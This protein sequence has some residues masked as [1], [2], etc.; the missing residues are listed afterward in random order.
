MYRCNSGYIPCD[1]QEEAR[2][3]QHEEVL[4]GI[5][6]QGDEF[7]AAMKELW[8]V[9][10]EFLS[11]GEYEAC[12]EEKDFEHCSSFAADAFI[13]GKFKT[14]E[15]LYD[16]LKLLRRSC[17][18]CFPP[19]TEVLMGDGSRKNIEDV[20]PGDQVLATDP[21]ARRTAVRGVTQQIVTEDDKHF[22]E[23]TVANRAGP[24]KLTAT[25]EHPFWSPSEQRWIGAGELAPGMTLLSSD[26]STVRVEGNRPFSQRQKTYN[27][28]VADIHT[29]YV[30][31]GDTPVLVHNS[32]PGCGTNWMSSDKIPHHY[33]KKS[34]QGVM[35]AED[36]GV[37]GPYNKA[38]AQ[39]FVQAVERFVKNPGTRQLQGTY[40]GQD[41][42]HYV[43]DT[44][45]HASFAANGPNVGEY[46]GGWRSTGDQ[47][48]HLLQN[49]KL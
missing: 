46:L 35:H 20:Q 22:N 29:Y 49:G 34:D 25:H 3:C 1:P 24:E 44:G 33:M 39:E 43:D 32:G 6:A 27:L 13:G 18:K 47:L 14:L 17:L 9:T 38:N 11:I 7:G 2:W 19:G 5:I 45:L 26:E 36:F 48:A 31:A 30:L 21:V 4:C 40:R 16:E 12:L 8:G 15:K 41:A 10:K 42:I 37:T 23:L 28:T